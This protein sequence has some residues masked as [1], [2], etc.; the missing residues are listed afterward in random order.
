MEFAAA[1]QA[2]NWVPG[3]IHLLRSSQQLDGGE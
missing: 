2:L 3:V 1:G